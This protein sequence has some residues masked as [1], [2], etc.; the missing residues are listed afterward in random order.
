L[1]VRSV[2]V[3][4]L[5]QDDKLI[6]IFEIFSTLPAAFSH[7][8]LGTLEVLA[9][10]ALKNA[11]AR[12]SSLVSTGLASTV[13]AAGRA[14]TCDGTE[15]GQARPNQRDNTLEYESLTA[16]LAQGTFAAASSTARPFDWL[17]L[18]MS[19]ESSASRF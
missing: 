14:R 7:G 3:L 16:Q 6:G 13:P 15:R 2:V 12:Q 19:G 11:Q 1:G 9:E 4:P 10:R 17:T 5:L 8:D 18:L